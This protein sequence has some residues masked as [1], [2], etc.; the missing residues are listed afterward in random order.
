MEDEMTSPHRLCN[1]DHAALATQAHGNRFA[2]RRAFL[3]PALGLERIGC[4]LIIVPPGKAAYP[5]HRHHATDELFVILSGE[6][7]HRW[8]D[9]RHSVK[10]GDVIAAPQG[11][12]AHQLVNTGTVDLRYLGISSSGGVD[13]VEYPD[14]GKVA[15][16]AGVQHADFSTATIK[17]LGKLGEPMSYYDGEPKENPSP[18]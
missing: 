9:E 18:S 16:A 4:S 13:I 17:F 1:L 8:G 3:G 10:A 15:F 5:F 14:S 6:G 2:F 12:E 7:Q 11:T